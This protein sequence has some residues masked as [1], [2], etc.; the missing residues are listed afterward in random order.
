M[1][2]NIITFSLSFLLP[3]SF[4]PGGMEQSLFVRCMHYCWTA[5]ITSIQTNWK[6]SVIQRRDQ[7]SDEMKRKKCEEKRIRLEVKLLAHVQNE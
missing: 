6:V 7:E 1:F 5:H 4:S 3:F 2:K